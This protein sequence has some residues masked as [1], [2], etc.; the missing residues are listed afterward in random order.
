M[1]SIQT[2]LLCSK[3]PLLAA[4]GISIKAGRAQRERRIKTRSDA[5]KTTPKEPRRSFRLSAGSRLR[6]I[7][8]CHFHLTQ[9][10][11]ETEHVPRTSLRCNIPSRQQAPSFL[12][13]KSQHNRISDRGHYATFRTMHNNIF[14][15]S[16]ILAHI[17]VLY[18]LIKAKNRIIQRRCF[19]TLKNKPRNTQE[20]VWRLSRERRRPTE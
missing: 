19:D 16:R 6:A 12:Q 2:R 10:D 3:F 11:Q 17:Y 18:I 14:N 20:K 8:S 15:H 4:P 7:W 9:R 13:A 5:R 1:V